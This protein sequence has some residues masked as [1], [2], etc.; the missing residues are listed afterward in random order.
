MSESPG[1]YSDNRLNAAYAFG[2]SP[3]DDTIYENFGITIDGNIEV[4]FERFEKVIDVLGG[5]DIVLTAAEAEHLGRRNL[6]GDESSGWENG[7]GICQ[8]SED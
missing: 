1:G 4:D 2:A 7:V 8:N 5:V 6:C 3:P